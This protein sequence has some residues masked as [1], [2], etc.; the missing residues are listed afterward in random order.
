MSD[1][2][3]SIAAVTAVLPD[4]T[5]ARNSSAT[6]TGAL[7]YQP[8]ERTRGSI[9]IQK[10]SGPS[11]SSSSKRPRVCNDGQS[12]NPSDSS[13]H[14]TPAVT[15]SGTPSDTSGGRLDSTDVT[16]G[17]SGISSSKR[18]RVCNDGRSRKPSGPPNYPTPAATFGTPSDT[19]TGHVDS[20]ERI[21]DGFRSARPKYHHCCMAGG[22]P[23]DATQSFDNAL[24]IK[25][26]SFI[27]QLCEL[28]TYAHTE[29]TSE[30]VKHGLDR[31]FSGFKH[32]GLTWPLLPMVAAA[33]HCQT[34]TCP[35]KEKKKK[36]LA[37]RGGGFKRPNGLK[38]LLGRWG[39]RSREK[40]FIE[41]SSIY[42]DGESVS[43]ALQC[44]NAD[45]DQHSVDQGQLTLVRRPDV[46]REV[47]KRVI[48]DAMCTSAILPSASRQHI[49]PNINVRRCLEPDD[50]AK[51]HIDRVDGVLSTYELAPSNISNREGLHEH[52]LP[53]AEL[54]NIYTTR[55]VHRLYM[56]NRSG[57]PAIKN[58]PSSS[59]C[60]KGTDF[61]C[62]VS[63]DFS[64][65]Q[66]IFL[67][68][69]LHE[70]QWS[71]VDL[72]FSGRNR[73]KRSAQQNQIGAEPYDK[74]RFRKSMLFR[75]VHDDTM[76]A[77]EEH[78]DRCFY[79]VAFF[80]LES[81]LGPFMRLD[82]YKNIDS[83]YFCPYE[84][85]M[86][87][88]DI[89]MYRNDQVG[90]RFAFGIADHR[91]SRFRELEW[92]A[93]S[94]VLLLSSPADRELE[95]IEQLMNIQSDEGHL[96]DILSLSQVLIQGFEV[97]LP[98]KAT[99]EHTIIPSTKGK[100]RKDVEGAQNFLRIAIHVNGSGW[101]GTTFSIHAVG[102]DSGLRT[103]LQVQPDLRIVLQRSSSSSCRQAACEGNAASIKFILF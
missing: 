94:L 15:T 14:Y 82:C 2:N 61:T 18:P 41:C 70:Q 79:A 90:K 59:T 26:Q 91:I 89:Y 71:H 36:A 25:P 49:R 46:W 8:R 51:E 44:I 4:V 84:K 50:M 30:G 37:Q 99:M 16:N 83:I 67:Y 102:N 57:V 31:P 101:T 11:G 58:R 6:P 7:S 56:T 1:V 39:Y 12:R 19:A 38:V 10:D 32:G 69:L 27:V 55:D 60:N 20:T 3:T 93:E 96:E 97:I 85:R 35:K 21:K 29:M 23:Y 100:S 76:G 88:E 73:S 53:A 13:N 52:I 42:V 68:V 45:T 80:I 92:V 43:L 28:F 24:A 17:P 63:M 33:C 22:C 54:Q 103:V 86:E 5:Y 87:G 65:F 47:K 72:L 78:L 64:A 40:E 98:G 66:T 77:K 34:E 81:Q 9:F 95:I 62:V 48:T 74:Y 75:L